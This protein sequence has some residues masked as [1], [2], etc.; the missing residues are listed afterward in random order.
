MD[1]VKLTEL[2]YANAFEHVMFA[3]LILMTPCVFVG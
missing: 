3:I 2:A 1:L